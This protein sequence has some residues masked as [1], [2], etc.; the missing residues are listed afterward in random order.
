MLKSNVV[1]YPDDKF[2]FEMPIVLPLAILTSWIWPFRSRTDCVPDL[3]GLFVMQFTANVKCKSDDK[4]CDYL[5][6]GNTGVKR[7]RWNNFCLKNHLRK[8]TW[9]WQFYSGW[10]FGWNDKGGITFVWRIIWEHTREGDNF[11][12]AGIFA[13]IN[14]CRDVSVTDGESWQWRSWRSTF[15]WSIVWKMRM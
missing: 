10:N 6:L 14:C 1:T 7:Q 2:D 11:I 3:N 12:V 13:T 4:V 9:G 5:H 8:R 15:V